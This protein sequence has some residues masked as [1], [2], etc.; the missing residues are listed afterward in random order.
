MFLGDALTAVPVEGRLGLFAIQA[1]RAG[2][3]ASGTWRWGSSLEMLDPLGQSSVGF[4]EKNQVCLM[5]NS[6]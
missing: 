4:Q 6:G 3:A 1:A 5:I 2:P